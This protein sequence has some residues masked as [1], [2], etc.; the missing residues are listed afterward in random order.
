MVA[1]MEEVS[2]FMTTAGANIRISAYS[3]ECMDAFRMND[4]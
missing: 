2:L 4:A 1:D 3:V